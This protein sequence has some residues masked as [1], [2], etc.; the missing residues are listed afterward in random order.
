MKVVFA[1]L[2]VLFMVGCVGPTEVVDRDESGNAILI[3]SSDP[4]LGRAK[5]LD[6]KENIARIFNVRTEPHS[7]T[8]LEGLAQEYHVPMGHKDSQEKL[9]E[10]ADKFLEVM[11]EARENE[12]KRAVLMHCQSGLHRTGVLAAV[13]RMEYQSWTNTEAYNEMV[14]KKYYH[15]TIHNIDGLKE[16]VLEYR[17]RAER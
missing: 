15:M 7:K 11:D 17:R 5:A 4:S 10:A 12:D 8:F 13:Y 14:G 2:G 1:A 6:R 3:R 16:F 9:Y